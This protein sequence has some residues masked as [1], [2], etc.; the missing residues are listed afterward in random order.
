V[1]ASGEAPT[2]HLALAPQI[3]SPDME[4]LGG[5]TEREPGERKASKRRISSGAADGR[6]PARYCTNCLCLQITVGKKNPL[7]GDSGKIKWVVY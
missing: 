4:M 6:G 1:E 3:H 5:G 2:F 7:W